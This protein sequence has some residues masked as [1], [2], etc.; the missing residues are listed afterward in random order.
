MRAVGGCKPDLWRVEAAPGV[1]WGQRVS[2][3]MKETEKYI[4]LGA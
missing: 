1:I 4:V 3:G 2:A